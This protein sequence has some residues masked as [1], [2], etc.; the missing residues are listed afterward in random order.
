MRVHQLIPVETWREYACGDEDDRSSTPHPSLVTCK[1]CK[2]VMAHDDA[3]RRSVSA[4]LKLVNP[5]LYA[6]VL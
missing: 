1:A 3:M 4:W 2:R 5:R 6:E